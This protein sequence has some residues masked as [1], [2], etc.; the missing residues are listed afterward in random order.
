MPFRAAVLGVPEIRKASPSIIL[1]QENNRE[2]YFAFCPHS[3]THWESD[4]RNVIV[5]FMTSPEYGFHE[6][7]HTLNMTKP[8]H[9]WFTENSIPKSLAKANNTHFIINSIGARSSLCIGGSKD[10][11]L[12]C[13]KSY[14]QK[15]GC[16][17]EDFPIQSRQIQLSSKDDC[18]S[19]F[20]TEPN[21]KERLYI[22]KKTRSSGGHGID[23]FQGLDTIRLKYGKCEYSRPLIIMDYIDKP[24][25][26]NGNKFDFR[27]YLLVASLKPRLVF[28]HDGLVRRANLPYNTSLFSNRNIHITNAKTQNRLDQY[29]FNLNE[30]LSNLLISPEKIIE[31]MKSLSKVLF[32]SSNAHSYEGRFH[33]FGIDWMLD[34]KFNLYLLEVNRNPIISTHYEALRPPTIWKDMLD[35]VLLVHTKKS[36]EDIRSEM[37]VRNNFTFKGWELIFNEMESPLHL[38][39]P[40]NEM[41]KVW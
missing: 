40:C 23:I 8:V 25:L 35:L 29:Y 31:K 34:E 22:V 11:Q 5:P 24:A 14:F 41:H 16:K 36:E 7:P 32:L 12:N 1:P 20:S 3:Q 15:F 37:L 9:F 33:L 19:F 13:R 26:L 38:E 2:N 4:W 28:Y 18:K 39:N 17:F 10:E 21:D 30:I 27:T 6:L